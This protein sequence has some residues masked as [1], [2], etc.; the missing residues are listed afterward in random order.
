[1]RCRDESNCRKEGPDTVQRIRD[2]REEERGTR[3]GRNV[4]C[5]ERVR[6]RTTK[7]IFSLTR[8]RY[9]AENSSRRKEIAREDTE[10]SMLS[11]IFIRL[12][13][14]FVEHLTDKTVK[15]PKKPKSPRDKFRYFSKEL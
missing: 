14:S 4:V 12:R 2:G 11:G 10:Y 1:M 13:E 8:L 9:K 15:E 6:P 7:I 5:T 3:N